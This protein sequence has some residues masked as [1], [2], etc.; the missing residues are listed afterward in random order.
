MDKYTKAVLAVIA[1]SVLALPAKAEEK[2]W[3]CEMT[4]FAHTTIEGDKTYKNETFKIKVSALEVVFGSG[5][6]FD[7][8]KMP[9]AN[10]LDDGRW[11]ATDDTSVLMFKGGEF[12]YGQATT[13]MGSVAVT[14]RCDDF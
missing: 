11:K 7:N 2:V 14:A 13:N 5:G 6:Y 12:N 3:Y 10:W 1:L 9:I 4:G 8:T